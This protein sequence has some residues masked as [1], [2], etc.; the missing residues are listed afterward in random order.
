MHDF[1]LRIDFVEAA[2]EE[3]TA[4]EAAVEGAQAVDVC[5][6]VHVDDAQHL[7]PF[8]SAG[9]AHLFKALAAKLLEVLLCLLDADE[10]A[11]D[12]H[13]ELFAALRHE[14]HSGCGVLAL[15]LEVLALLAFVGCRRVGKGTVELQDE[16]VLEAFG[17]A[18]TV[19][20]RV[21]HHLVLSGDDL[22][23]GAAVEGI[24]DKEVLALGT[25][26]TEDGGTARRGNLGGDVVV[27]QVNLVVVRLAH[28]GLVAEP[29]GAFVLIEDGSVAGLG[30]DVEHG[31]V[32]H[33]GTGLV[34]LLE[35]ANLVGIIGVAPSVAHH[36][37]LG[38]PEVHAPGQ[39]DGRIGVASGEG[40]RGVRAY[41]GID[42]LHR[43]VDSVC[44]R[45]KESGNSCQK[46]SFHLVVNY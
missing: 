10:R 16:V 3:G 23:V 35:A 31:V 11:G 44:A 24:D 32:V 34:S 40:W 41:E 38:C 30:H 1:A 5:V 46:E 15:H 26:E 4:V 25:G 20:R 13:V 6:V 42:I 12:T 18:A 21:A 27:G 39:C 36:A 22:D 9:L 29:A 17:H 7:V 2:G 28:L 37:G 19:A 43:V 45:E 8:L 33:P 14:A